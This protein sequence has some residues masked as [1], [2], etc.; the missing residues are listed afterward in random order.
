MPSTQFD[1]AD[2]VARFRRL[3]RESTS[4]EFPQAADIYAFLTEGENRV[5]ADIAARFPALLLCN[6]TALA[7]TDSISY[8]FG[9]DADGNNV[10]PLGHVIVY[11]QPSDVPHYPLM[12]GAEFVWQ[13]DRIRMPDNAPRTFPTGGPVAQW[14]APTLLIDASNA[15]TLKPVQA[16]TLVVYDAA[17]RYANAIKS[18]ADATRYENLYNREWEIWL[19]A[20]Q[21]QAQYLPACTYPRSAMRQMRG[22]R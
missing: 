14:V 4:A 5:K 13:G 3:T 21:T 16:R 1:T 22:Y 2:L 10:V 6:P 7:T 8:T 20:F 17:V 9:T 15:P 11:A 19:P 12:T 18:D